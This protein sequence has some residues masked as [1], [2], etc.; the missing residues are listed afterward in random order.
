GTEVTSHLYQGCQ[1]HSGT[2][3]PCHEKIMSITAGKDFSLYSE[4]KCCHMKDNCNN[5]DSVSVP[6]EDHKISSWECPSC[7]ALDKDNCTATMTKCVQSQD[8][9]VN[10][11]GNFTQDSKTHSF[12]IKGCATSSTASVLQ[13]KDAKLNF[14]SVTYTIGRITVK[15]GK[16]SINRAPGS[17]VFVVFLPSL[18]GL[19]MNKFLY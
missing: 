14:G 4:T 6:K 11:T 10:I 1:E 12:V 17:I 15:N 13:E 19:L 2:F 9:C 18:L 3:D 7:F 8:R 16:D 5:N